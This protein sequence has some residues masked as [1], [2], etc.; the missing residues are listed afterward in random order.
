MFIYL[1]AALG[2]SMFDPLNARFVPFHVEKSSETT[3]SQDGSFG[4]DMYI[5]AISKEI[6]E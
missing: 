6:L 2:E 5:P 4:G 1:T 3:E